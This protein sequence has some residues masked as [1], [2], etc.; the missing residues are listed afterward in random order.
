MFGENE[1]TWIFYLLK[2]SA[3]IFLKKD[4]RIQ[5]KFRRSSY[6]SFVFLFSNWVRLWISD[7]YSRLDLKVDSLLQCRIPKQMIK[8]V[9]DEAESVL[10]SGSLLKKRS[11]PL[12]FSGVNS[13]ILEWSIPIMAHYSYYWI[14][15]NIGEC[16]PQFPLL[17]LWARKMMVS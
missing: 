1:V 9:N 4:K 8:S 10:F 3:S 5:F 15:S 11:W 6:C 2:Y 14:H 17:I 16:S 13:A 12:T 7:E